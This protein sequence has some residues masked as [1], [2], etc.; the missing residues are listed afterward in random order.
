M[1]QKILKEL[2]RQGSVLGRVDLIRTARIPII[3]CKTPEVT[4]L[5]RAHQSAQMSGGHVI[6]IVRLCCL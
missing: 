5:L 4:L 1:L 2:R 6:G 3:K